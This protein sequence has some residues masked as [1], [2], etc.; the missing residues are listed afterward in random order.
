MKLSKKS[1]F[2]TC[3]N[4]DCGMKIENLIIVRDVSTSPKEQY[5]ACPH[6]LMK[7]DVVCFQ[8]LK[9]Q[10][11]RR[12]ENRLLKSPEREKGCPK[13]GSYLGYLATL[14]E[15]EPIPRECLSCPKVLDCSMKTS[16]YQ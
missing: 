8:V 5:Y 13:C 7:L 12:K 15:G 2:V 14:P 9:E 6:C 4:P 11:D 3:P 1:E 16:D 10:A